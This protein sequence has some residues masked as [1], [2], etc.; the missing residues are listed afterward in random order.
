MSLEGISPAWRRARGINNFRHKTGQIHEGMIL[1]GPSVDWLDAS[2][3]K[4]WLTAEEDQNCG[5]RYTD[6]KLVYN[7]LRALSANDLEAED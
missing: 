4:S 3:I 2:D 5:S 7:G 1:H 6:V